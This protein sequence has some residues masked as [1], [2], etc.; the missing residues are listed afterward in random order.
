MLIRI[1][2]IN[3]NTAINEITGYV[4]IEDFLDQALSTYR[5]IPISEKAVNCR[6]ML[7]DDNTLTIWYTTG[8]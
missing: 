6:D 5:D 4:Q 1:V 8:A 7:T 2:F 3:N